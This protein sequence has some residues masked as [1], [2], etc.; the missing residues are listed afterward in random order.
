[1]ENDLDFFISKFERVLGRWPEHVMWSITQVSSYTTFSD[2]RVIDIFKTCTGKSFSTDD[3]ISLI[4]GEEIFEKVVNY[5]KKYLEDRQQSIEEGYNKIIA[6]AKDA[7]NNKFWSKAYQNIRYYL[8]LHQTSLSYEKLLHLHNEALRYGIKSDRN[9]QELFIILNERHKIFL[10]DKNKEYLSDLIDI[11]DAFYEHFIK[12][13]HGKKLV[14]HLM[15]EI[16]LFSEQLGLN[17]Q[18]NEVYKH[19]NAAA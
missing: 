16:E 10:Q 18:W 8:S 13:E 5:H 4:E 6:K 1:M 12:F 7:E 2:D 15:E 19:F 9:V 3:K 11:I 17:E 14:V